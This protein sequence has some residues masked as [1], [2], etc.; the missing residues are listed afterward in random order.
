MAGIPMRSVL[1][2][3]SEGFIGRNLR[4]WLERR[5]DIEI[6]PFDLGNT[7]EDLTAALDRVDFVFHLA[8]INR[9]K[10]VKEFESGNKGLTEDVISLLLASGRRVPLL[11]A[12]TIQ[13]SLD[14]PY[15]LSKRGAEIA[16]ASYGEKTNGPVFVFRLPNVFGKWCRPHYNSVIATWCHNTARGL[17]LQIDD[18][19]KRLSLV[20]IDDVVEAFID[21]LDG[22][23]V[24]GED[25]F[26]RVPREY[27]KSLGEIA[28]SLE[29]FSRSRSSLVMPNLEDDFQRRLYGTWLSYLPEDRFSYPLEMKRDARGWLSEFMKSPPFGQIFI[30]TTKPGVT[31]GNHWHHTKVEKFLVISGNGLVRF[32]KIGSSEVLEYP[33]SGEELTVIDIPV[34][35]THSITNIGD[36]ELITLFWADE[37]FD[38]AAPDTYFLEV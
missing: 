30:S 14:N 2:T 11:I 18:P 15:G 20:Y 32:R 17:P 37:L 10:D 31:R 29:S 3:G 6:V 25:G 26:C 16:A 36:R 34:G 9:P 21:A 24:P 23:I 38:P 33:V 8:G 35:Y 12:S 4:A 22:R 13:A 28:S 5:D 27:E 7:R 19:E 1:V